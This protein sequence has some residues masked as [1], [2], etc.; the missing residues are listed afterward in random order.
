M[1]FASSGTAPLEF[2]SKLPHDVPPP[3]PSR[4]FEGPSQRRLDDSHERTFGQRL[5]VPASG[6]GAGGSAVRIVRESSR[7]TY[8]RALGRTTWHDGRCRVV[9]VRACFVLDRVA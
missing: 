4:S 8:V 2:L 5:A 1:G 6:L 9:F 3:G 7:T